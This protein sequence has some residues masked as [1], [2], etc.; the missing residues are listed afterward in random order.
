MIAVYDRLVRQ[1]DGHRLMPSSTLVLTNRAARRLADLLMPLFR[2]VIGEAYAEGRED[3]DR[4]RSEVDEL[5][6]LLG[7]LSDAIESDR[8][9]RAN[10]CVRVVVERVRAR[11]RQ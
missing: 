11:L 8:A 10:P 6:E 5:R 3:R 1:L 7:E 2:D 9:D 4:L